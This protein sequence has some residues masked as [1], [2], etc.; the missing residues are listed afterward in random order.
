MCRAWENY[1]IKKHLQTRIYDCIM[2]IN[3]D[4][5]IAV[6]KLFMRFLCKNERRQQ[7]CRNMNV[8]HVD[9]SMIRK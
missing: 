9:T 1:S 4:M 6:Y 5:R 8:A 3:S 2:T 7:R